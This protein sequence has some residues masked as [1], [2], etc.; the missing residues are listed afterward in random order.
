MINVQVKSKPNENTTNLIR[1]FS[2]RVN[3]SGVLSKART[4]KSHSRDLSKNMKKKQRIRSL[5]QLQ[6][7][8]RL[9]KLGKLPD[10]RR[11]RSFNPTNES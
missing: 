8:E 5:E 1:R 9:I 3:S 6:Q 7:V 11:G 2:R 10:R 4:L